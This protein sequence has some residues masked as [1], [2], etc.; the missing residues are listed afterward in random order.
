VFVDRRVHRLLADDIYLIWD[1]FGV[2]VKSLAIVRASQPPRVR[3]LSA[4]SK[5]PPDDLPFEDILII[6]RVHYRIGRIVRP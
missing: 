6:G 4:N 5:Y 3:V 1:G 2:V